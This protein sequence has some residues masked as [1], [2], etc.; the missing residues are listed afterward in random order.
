MAD[1]RLSVQKVLIRE[2]GFV[3][4]PLDPGGPTNKGIILK[5]WM[6]YGRDKD[7]DGDIDI[8][9]LKMITDSDAMV[10]Y[11]NQF[12]DRIHG[13]RINNQALADIVFDMQVNAPSVAVKLL[14]RL[15]N[16]FGSTL[17]TDGIIGAKTLQAL[18]GFPDPGLLHDQYKKVREFYYRYRSAT[19]GFPVDW[20]DFFKSLGIKALVSQRVFLKGWLARVA[21]F[22]DVKKKELPV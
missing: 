18:N 4:N 3:N 1:F 10:L 15:L 14:Q 22:P 2:G 7:L 13:D 8:E 12:W 6:S 20:F 19:P 9:D 5:N 11:K 21:S 16:F 17:A